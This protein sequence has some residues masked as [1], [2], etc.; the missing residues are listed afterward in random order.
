MLR[1]WRPGQPPDLD[2]VTDPKDPD[3][4]PPEGQCE[5]IA[6]YDQQQTAGDRRERKWPEWSQPD[7]YALTKRDE[8]RECRQ[9]SWS[10]LKSDLHGGLR[11]GSRSRRNFPT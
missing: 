1:I 6:Q 2:E 7:L 10:I 5:V 11:E 8:F 3:Q 4:Q 9:V